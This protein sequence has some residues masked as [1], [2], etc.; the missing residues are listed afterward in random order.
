MLPPEELKLALD[1]HSRSYK[2]LRWLG[3]AIDTGEI[4]LPRVVS[5]RHA[6]DV[7]AA[8]L[9]WIEPFHVTFPADMRPDED[10]LRQFA[11]FFGTYL[12]S[13][14]DITNDFG[15]VLRNQ[16][17]GT[18][19]CSICARLVNGSHL[20]AKKLTSSDKRRSLALMLDRIIELAR[21]H[22]LKLKTSDAEALIANPEYKIAAAYSTYGYWLIQRTKG[23]T[24]G[25]SILGLWR[26]FAW[27]DA[28]SPRK[29]F[30]LD[31]DDFK[32]SEDMLLTSIRELAV[33]HL[34]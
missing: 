11:A 4:P 26:Q 13:S 3:R 33:D 30:K 21:E 1:I 32:K 5:P 20:K 7:T 16:Y 23:V 24:D 17:G 9:D 15:V 19:S 22:D 2:L 6:D 34:E 12:T 29:D 25:P 28:G 27:T 14:F 31:Y 8:T 18:C 10:K